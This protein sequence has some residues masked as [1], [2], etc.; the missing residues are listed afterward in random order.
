[1]PWIY[2]LSTLL[3]SLSLLGLMINVNMG[4]AYPFF[5]FYI[6]EMVKAFDIFLKLE[7]ALE[8]DLKVSMF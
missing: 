5:T 8:E 2:L 1:M 4:L 3:F 7:L 6:Y